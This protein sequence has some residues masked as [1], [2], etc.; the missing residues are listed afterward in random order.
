VKILNDLPFG[1]FDLHIHT[2]ASDGDLTPA[3]VV[4]RA[5]LAG[6]STIAITDH[7][8]LAGIAEAYEMGKKLRITVIPG[9]EITTRYQGENIDILGYNIQQ[10][11]QFH[12][13]LSPFR[14]ARLDRAE[15]IVHRFTELGMPLTM[16]DVKK[17][18]GNGIIA[19]PHIAKAVVEKG[20]AQTVQEAFQLYLAD[21]KPVALDKK[22]LSTV[23]G[24]EMIHQAGGVAVLAHPVYIKESGRIEELIPLGLDGLEVWHRNHRKEDVD[25]FLQIAKQHDLLITGGSDFHTAEHPL[26]QFMAE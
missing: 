5:K 26:G 10:G 3:E 7:D 21:G 18:S 22:R 11:D 16:E 17:Y 12:Q 24:I 25:A 8:T 1:T 23:A 15:R 20:Y 13:A 19:R 2:T 14:A 6:I 4:V 9:V